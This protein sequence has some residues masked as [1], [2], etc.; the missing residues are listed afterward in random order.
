MV[1]AGKNSGLSW[2]E[3][4]ALYHGSERALR[5]RLRSIAVLHLQHPQFAHLSAGLPSV[6][7][8]LLLKGPLGSE[9]YQEGVVRCAAAGASGFRAFQ[10]RWAFAI[11]V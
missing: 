10:P 3:L 2:A 6:S 7:N 8:R 11:E 5:Q 9:L 4:D 1:V